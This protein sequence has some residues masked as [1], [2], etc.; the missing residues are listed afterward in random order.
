MGAEGAKVKIRQFNFKLAFN[1]LICKGTG[2]SLC[3]LL[4]AYGIFGL[5]RSVLTFYDKYLKNQ[6]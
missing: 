4:C 6:T 3:P 2:L 1:G 5:A